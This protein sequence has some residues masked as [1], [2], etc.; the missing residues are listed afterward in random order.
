[1]K[2]IYLGLSKLNTAVFLLGIYRARKAY[3]Y[4]FIGFHLNLGKCVEIAFNAKI[5]FFFKI[6]YYYSL[7]CIFHKCIV[8][9]YLQIKYV[10]SIVNK[11]LIKQGIDKLFLLS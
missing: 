9:Y 4:T 11:W 1:M 8:L 2:V 7:S 10:V 5:K 6:N 3:N